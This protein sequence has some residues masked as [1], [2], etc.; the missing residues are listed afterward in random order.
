MIAL[1]SP[2]PAIK[3]GKVLVTGVNGFIAGWVAKELLDQGF[4][5]RGT[6]RS[7]EKAAPIR[8]ALAG[9]GD[10]LEFAVVQDIT[11][12]SVRCT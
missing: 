5:V 6:V 4:S 2:M 12:V 11:Q 9:Y 10:R 8:R 7:L 1:A 3:S